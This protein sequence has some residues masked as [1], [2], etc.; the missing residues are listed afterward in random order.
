MNRVK[1]TKPEQYA[2]AFQY[3]AEI[4]ARYRLDTYTSH[5]QGEDTYDR[6][7]EETYLPENNS[8]RTLSRLKRARFSWFQHMEDRGRHH[9][10]ATPED[11][12]IW[13][14]KLLNA[15]RAVRTCY[16]YYYNMIYQFYDYLKF[17]HQHP[18]LYNPLLL[19]AVHNES[20]RKIW[21]CRVDRRPEVLTRE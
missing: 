9:A 1:G 2:G 3:Y 19:A 16:D 8:E 4:P 14:Q 18:H 17:N 21:M 12:E 15:D 5:Y 7:V 20:A 10:L 11:A 6:Y 13:C